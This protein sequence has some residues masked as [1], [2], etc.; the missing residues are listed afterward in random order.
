MA[1][2]GFQGIYGLLN[3]RDDVVCERAFLPDEQDMALHLRTGTPLFSLESKRPVTAFD[4]AAF[5]FPLRMTTLIYSGSW[6]VK[7]TV[8]VHAARP[9]PSASDRRRR[10]PL[11]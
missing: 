9:F 4:I 6:T 10:L 5:S 11:V 3:K 2:L 1:N 7:N 8:P